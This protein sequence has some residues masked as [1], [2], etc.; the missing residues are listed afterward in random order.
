MSMTLYRDIQKR[1][2]P[3][4]FDPIFLS[5]GLEG[6]SDIATCH[7]FTERGGQWDSPSPFMLTVTQL[8]YHLQLNSM[9]LYAEVRVHFRVPPYKKFLYESLI[10]KTQ[11]HS[12]YSVLSC[13]FLSKFIYL[14]RTTPI[15][16][17]FF[18][19]LEK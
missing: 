19:P 7:G 4:H 5:K 10:A 16:S 12:A 14:F 17:K 15:V 11:L 3:Y 9:I 8:M 18:E 2:R 13:N 1:Q 6:P